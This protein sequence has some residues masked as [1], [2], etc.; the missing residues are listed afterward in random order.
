VPF[1]LTLP[2]IVFGLIGGVVWFRRRR[3]VPRS[4][5]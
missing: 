3:S 4:V 1:T 2:I 5:G